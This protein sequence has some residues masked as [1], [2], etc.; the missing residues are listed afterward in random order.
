MSFNIER[1]EVKQ[2]PYITLC[3]VP[4]FKANIFPMTETEFYKVTF[5][6]EEIFTKEMALALRNNSLWTVTT[7]KGKSSRDFL[8]Y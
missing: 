6:E 2:L 4:V 7:Q 3:P 1:D 5:N 8:L